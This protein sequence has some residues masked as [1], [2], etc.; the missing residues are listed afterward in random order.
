MKDYKTLNAN[1]VPRNFNFF[2]YFSSSVFRIFNV[3][4]ILINP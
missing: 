3:S 4:L 1:F 2:S